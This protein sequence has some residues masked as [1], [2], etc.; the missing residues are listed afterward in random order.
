MHVQC[1]QAFSAAFEKRDKFN[2]FFSSKN[3]YMIKCIIIVYYY[4]PEFFQVYRLNLQLIVAG[5]HKV[6]VTL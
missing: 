3:D 4:L 6:L 2:V 5:N 1:P